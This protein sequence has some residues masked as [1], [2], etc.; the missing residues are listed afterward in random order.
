MNNPT[1]FLLSLV[2]IGGCCDGAEKNFLHVYDDALSIAYADKKSAM[3]KSR[4]TLM[5]QSGAKVDNCSAYFAL[6]THEPIAEDAIN[7][8][9]KSEYLICDALTLLDQ[10]SIQWKMPPV[11]EALGKD[12]LTRLD[13]RSFPSSLFMKTTKTHFTLQNLY[14][15]DSYADAATASYS[16]ADWIFTVKVVAVADLNHNQQPDW[17]VWVAD[18]AVTGNYRAYSTVVIYDPADNEFINAVSYPFA[19]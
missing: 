7:Q 3:E 11:N 2:G 10:A 14:P 9:I 6:A 19:P 16:T 18:E 13:L 17:I 4:S 8:R 15:D 1:V 12:L 5:F